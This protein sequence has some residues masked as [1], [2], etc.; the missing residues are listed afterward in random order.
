MAIAKARRWT[1]VVTSRDRLP[2]GIAAAIAR[3]RQWIVAETFKGRLLQWIAAAIA[4]D[5]Q[6]TAGV[7]VKAPRP[8]RLMAAMTGKVRLP[9]IVLHLPKVGSLTRTDP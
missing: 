8:R 4:K 7:T 9:M 3:D 2:R 6:W 1:V 5:R